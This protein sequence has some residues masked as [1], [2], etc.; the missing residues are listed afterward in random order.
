MIYYT[1]SDSNMKMHDIHLYFRYI[2][3]YLLFSDWRTEVRLH[4]AIQFFH[5]LACVNRK[6]P[7]KQEFPKGTEKIGLE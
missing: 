3:S 4:T 5:K 6:G 1:I 2:N 7:R